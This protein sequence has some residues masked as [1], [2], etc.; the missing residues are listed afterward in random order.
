MFG[1]KVNSF[2]LISPNLA[3]I[4]LFHVVAHAKG[5]DTD[6]GSESSRTTTEFA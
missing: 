6:D 1:F 2:P 4:G 3:F 5:S